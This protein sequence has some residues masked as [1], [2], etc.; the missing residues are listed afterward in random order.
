MTK[1]L[2][3]SS[4]IYIDGRRISKIDPVYF[5]AEIGSNFD[6]D[7]NRAKDLIYMAKNSGA[8]AV[9]FQHYTAKTLVSDLG[10]KA[11][12]NSK[13]H[14]ASWTKTVYETYENASLN[15]EWT[16]SL[17][18]TCTNAGLSF[19]TSPYAFD[20]VDLVDSYVPAFKIGSGD[21][22]WIEIIKYKTESF[23]FIINN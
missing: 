1:K 6:Q 9:K 7:L 15:P 11:L 14:Q 8:D 19:F 22:T 12:G 21:I 17:K 3:P 4:K 18:E 10:F 23:I 5:I 20:L 2:Q 16:L 13:S